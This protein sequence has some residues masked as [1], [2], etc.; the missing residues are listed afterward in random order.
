[1]APQNIILSCQRSETNASKNS[2]R[3]QPT[4]PKERLESTTRMRALD[5][6]EVTRIAEYDDKIR[7]ITVPSLEPTVHP[8]LLDIN[9]FNRLKQQAKV[10]KVEHLY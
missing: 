6:K 1:M 8:A 7:E 5:S 2:R 9:E 10:G 4:K 3:K